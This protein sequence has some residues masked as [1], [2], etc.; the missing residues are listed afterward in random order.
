[1]PIE[2][3]AVMA[4]AGT[5]MLAGT[6]VALEVADNETAA[7]PLGASAFNVTVP[8]DELPATTLVG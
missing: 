3:L 1:V 2:K 6:V 8:V 7:P 5:M 4:A